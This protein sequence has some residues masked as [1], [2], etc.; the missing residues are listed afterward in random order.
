[1]NR[2]RA[3]LAAGAL[4]LVAAPLQAQIVSERVDLAAVQRI[5]DE[6]LD[7]SKLD[8]LIGYVTDVIGGR[9]GRLTRAVCAT[10]SAASAAS[11]ARQRYAP[12]ERPLCPRSTPLSQAGRAHVREIC[13]AQST[14]RPK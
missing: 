10:C 14:V 6:A 5:R 2:V 3:F 8:S 1:M 12:V 4:A 7:R 13:A 9:L 11:A